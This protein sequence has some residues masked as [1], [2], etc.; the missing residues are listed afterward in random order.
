LR[1][2]GDSGRGSDAG[3]APDVAASFAAAVNEL[4]A[5]NGS[6][7]PDFLLGE[8]LRDVL[9]VFDRTIRE[10]DRWYGVHLE[11]A[12][13]ARRQLPPAP[14]FLVVAED[15]KFGVRAW[16]YTGREAAEQAAWFWARH[17]VTDP[18]ADIVVEDNPNFLL[19]L[20]YPGEDGNAV[21]VVERVFDRPTMP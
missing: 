21:W 10:R 8:M 9:G 17:R 16:L 12:V 15:D 18:A 5:E 3:A 11:P 14:V 6:N 13:Q 4:S 20:N 7:T 19:L 1:Y 2:G